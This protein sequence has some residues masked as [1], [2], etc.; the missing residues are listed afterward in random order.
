MNF[1][2]LLLTGMLGLS[3]IAHAK[4]NKAVKT[5]TSTQKTE[6]VLTSDNTLIMDD[7]M[8]DDTVAKVMAK[9][10]ELDSKLKSGYPL[11]LVLYTPGGSIQA[12]LE[13]ITFLNG[14]NRPVHTITQFAA[15]MGFQTVQGLGKRY[16]THFGTLMA[17]KASGAF[18]GEFPG[19]IDSRY[20]YYI[21]RLNEMD[22]ITASRSRGQLTVKSL[23]A[24]YENEYWVDGFD[25]VKIGL[26]DEVINIR[27]DQSLSGTRKMNIESYFGS[28]ELT[29]SACPT[30]MGPLEVTALLHTNQGLLPL[31][32]FL[33]RGGQF[34]DVE[35]YTGYRSGYSEAQDLPASVNIPPV[36]VTEG[37]TLEKVNQE[38]SKVRE[39]RKLKPTVVKNQN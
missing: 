38:I 24:L 18:R 36:T 21:K 37:L 29:L 22:R 19:Q 31:P 5:A 35:T 2:T 30:I 28:V 11:Y 32:E 10:Q 1:K 39:Q 23:Q 15:S 9:A 3:T 34:K 8:M 16:I 25:A 14:L 17:H 4:K 12:G 33:K 6:I 27:C 20:V 13:L 7:V 26:A